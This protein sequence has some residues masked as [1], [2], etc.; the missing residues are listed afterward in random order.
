MSFKSY[1]S[2]DLDAPDELYDA[3][4]DGS[5][6]DAW[7]AEV[8]KAQKAAEAAYIKELEILLPSDDFYV[9]IESK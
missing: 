5:Q 2:V 6:L 7:W 9:D 8:H 4:D 1:I 3:D